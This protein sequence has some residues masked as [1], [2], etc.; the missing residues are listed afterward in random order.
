MNRMNFRVL[1]VFGTR[2]E[3]I[4]LAPVVAE[5]KKEK[6]IRSYVCVTG[7]HRHMLEQVLKIFSIKPDIDLNIMKIDQSL[8]DIVFGVMNGMVKVF[9]KIKPDIVLVQGDTTTAFIVA[10]S[11][12]FRKVKVAHV[13]A[14]L[15][16]YDK[17]KPYPEEVNRRLLSHVADLH[18]APTGGAA[19]NLKK[20]N[21]DKNTIFVTGNTVIDALLEIAGRKEGSLSRRSD[22]KWLSKITGGKKIILVTAH[23]RE[24]FGQDMDEM[25]R[26]I[27]E[28][29]VSRS[30]VEIVYPVHLNPNVRRQVSGILKNVPRVH[31][32]EPLEY[33]SFVRLMK[34]SCIILTDSGGVQEEAPALNKPVLVMR[35]ITERPEGVEAGCAMLVGTKRRDIVR[36]VVRLLD[37]PKLY[38]KMAK[39]K[40]PYGNGTAAK[41]IVG[42]LKDKLSKTSYNKTAPGG[43]R[44]K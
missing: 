31:L 18:F 44:K 25:F 8:E 10:L 4:K 27:R 37:D 23:R 42:I 24:S 16:S 11:A 3:A 28:I 32:V 15:R 35:H 12:F 5:L 21:I 1:T 43:R 30:D 19:E 41:K 40:N 6:K 9:D 20:E 33:D 17:F 39:S 13:E 2:P 26:A 36:G 38:F 14:G 7:Q 22:E 34:R 29:A